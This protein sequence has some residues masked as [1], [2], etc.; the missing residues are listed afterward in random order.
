MPNFNKIRP[1]GTAI[2]PIRTGQGL[3][4]QLDM[5][6]LIVALRKFTNAPE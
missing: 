3:T 2:F 6:E 1:V 4:D 5:M